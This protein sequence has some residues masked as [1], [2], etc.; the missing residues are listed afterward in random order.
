[1]HRNSVN[2]KVEAVGMLEEGRADQGHQM[3]GVD[4]VVG[5]LTNGLIKNVWKVRKL[6]WKV[7]L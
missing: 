2:T 3:G 4:S 7:W 1:M 5:V 6:A